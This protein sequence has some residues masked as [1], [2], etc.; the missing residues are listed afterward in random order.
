MTTR[1]TSELV[2]VKEDVINKLF[3][4]APH[5][6]AFLNSIKKGMCSTEIVEWLTDTDRTAITSAANDFVT[7][8]ESNYLSSAPTTLNNRVERLETFVAVSDKAIAVDTYG[9]SSAFNYQV[10][11]GVKSIKDGMETNMVGTAQAAVASIANATPA[12]AA[13]YLHYVTT[14]TKAASGVSGSDGLATG[15]QNILEDDINDVMEAIWKVSSVEGNYNLLVSPKNKRA[16]SKLLDNK[17]NVRR[18]LGFSGKKLNSSF[19]GYMGDFGDIAIMPSQFLADSVMFMYNPSMFE[20]TT[21]KGFSPKVTML[22][23]TNRSTRGMIDT[24]YTL[25]SFNELAS[26]RITGVT[27]L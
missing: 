1:T 23:K 21:L 24:A 19:T 16:I 8:S 7:P 5:R 18:D 15:D 17:S 22:S 10:V 4:V 26:G 27:T 14:N 20:H 2:G 3:N 9:N 11:K 25:K 13:N 6:H 12:Q